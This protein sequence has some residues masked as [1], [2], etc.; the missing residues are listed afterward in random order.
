MAKNYESIVA[1]NAEVVAL[2]TDDL[3]GADIAVKNFGAGFPIVYTDG[4]PAIPRQ[5]GVFN[6]HGD[7]L[8]SAAI[9]IF[10]RSGTLAW[11]SVGEQYS[12]TVPSATIIEALEQIGA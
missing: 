5:Y 10:D 2:S 9:F 11:K 8:A 7:G 12:T 3:R 6:L 1:R 4:D